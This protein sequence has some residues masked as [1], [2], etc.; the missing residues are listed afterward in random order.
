MSRDL[1][2]LLVKYATL[3]SDEKDYHLAIGFLQN[4]RKIEEKHSVHTVSNSSRLS[5]I[6]E[7]I[8]IIRKTIL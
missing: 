6:K 1:V 8:E 4:A 3:L 5:D 7:K 2:P